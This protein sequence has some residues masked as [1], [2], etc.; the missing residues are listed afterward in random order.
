M[1]TEMSVHSSKVKFQEKLCNDREFDDSNGNELIQS[2]TC[3]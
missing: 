2:K 1:T 3:I